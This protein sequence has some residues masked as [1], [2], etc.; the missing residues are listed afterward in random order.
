[1]FTFSLQILS[2]NVSRSKNKW[3]WYDQNVYWSSCKVPVVLVRFEET[4]IFSTDFRKTLKSPYFITIRPVVAKFFHADRRDEN[5]VTY[6][7]SLNAPQKVRCLF[8][9]PPYTFVPVRQSTWCHIPVL[10]ACDIWEQV[11]CLSVWVAGRHE[12]LKVMY[13]GHLESKER[14]RIQPAQLFNFSWCVMWCV[15]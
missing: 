4:W 9:V 14:L 5:A 8:H 2:G 3:A 7:D 10:H 12:T 13:V 15:Q 11:L 1:M 6:R